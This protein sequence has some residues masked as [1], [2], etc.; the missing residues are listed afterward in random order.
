MPRFSARQSSSHT[1][2]F[3]W[4]VFSSMS[5]CRSVALYATGESR[6]SPSLTGRST[7][8]CPGVSA[9]PRPCCHTRAVF[10]AAHLRLNP[11]GMLNSMSAPAPRSET[12]PK[13]GSVAP[14]NAPPEPKCARN[15][16]AGHVELRLV[17]NDTRSRRPARSRGV[18]PT[19]S[20]RPRPM[21]NLF[22]FCSRLDTSDAARR[23]ANACP[24]LA[25]STVER[26]RPFA[27]C[28]AWFT[29]R[30]N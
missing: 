16:G 6:V 20:G 18:R 22:P 11:F 2:M 14:T 26:G 4:P 24:P 3:T 23:S 15:S 13:L 21:R 12:F 8:A 30:A 9:P 25:A 29:A 7:T 17:K 28:C 5:A 19:A 27:E 10:P 1:T